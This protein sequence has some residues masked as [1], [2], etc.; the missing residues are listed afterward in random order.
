MKK[1]VNFS[2]DFFFFFLMI[3]PFLLLLHNKSHLMFGQFNAFNV[4][5][6]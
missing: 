2:V 3:S 6:L 5:Q 1:T 4:A